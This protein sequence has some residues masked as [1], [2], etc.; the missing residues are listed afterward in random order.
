MVRNVSLFS[1]H[2]YLLSL[3]WRDGIC[4]K[5]PCNPPLQEQH[6][7]KGQTFDQNPEKQRQHVKQ[8][9]NWTLL[10]K[11]TVSILRIPKVFIKLQFPSIPIP[12]IPS[13]F[14][15][16]QLFSF[17]Y[18]FLLWNLVIVFFQKKKKKDF[19][20]LFTPTNFLFPPDKWKFSFRRI[21]KEIRKSLRKFTFEHVLNFSFFHFHFLWL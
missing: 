6:L 13:N 19:C 8:Q 7:P 4:H 17:L 11:S 20:Y 18:F 1:S 2:C 3:P 12:G 16:L 10:N 5:T 15:F 14:L 21:T 9:H